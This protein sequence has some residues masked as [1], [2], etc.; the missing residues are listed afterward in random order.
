MEGEG[1]TYLALLW[2]SRCERVHPSVWWVHNGGECPSSTCEAT[3][4]DAW[5][6]GG[7]R[8]R[9]HSDWPQVPKPGERYEHDGRW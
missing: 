4:D 3:Y 6:W 5:T 7:F 8:L 2:C 1:F 9:E